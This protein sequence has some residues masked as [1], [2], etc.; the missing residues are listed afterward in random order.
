MIVTN[1]TIQDYWFGPLHLPGG[2]G[3]QL[4]V[5]DTTATSLYLTN[6]AVADAINNLYN[7]GK[8]T[9]ASAAIPFPRPTGMPSVLHGDGSPEGLVYAP[10][11]SIYL[12]RDSVALSTAIYTKTTG[13]TLNTG[14][15]AATNA[16]G[17]N[18]VGT[19]VASACPQAPSGMALCD[20]SAVSRTTYQTLFTAIC[21]GLGTFTVTIASPAVFA[22]TNHGLVAGDAV[23]FTTTGALPT[24]LSTNTVYYV[25]AAGLTS[26]NFE[27]STSRGGA[28]V[29]TSG[30]QNGVHSIVRCPWGLGDGSTTF[31]LPD[32]R[33]R[34]LVGASPGGPIEVAAL[35]TTDAVTQAQR[36]VSHHHTNA[37]TGG[38]PSSGGGQ[39]TAAPTTNTSGDANNTDAPAHAAINYF[40]QM[41]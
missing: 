19:I 3:Q 39:S 36:N 8:I 24:G 5:D 32:G 33:G 35:G 37:A 29:N 15:L 31:N 18:P 27:V 30:S 25:I 1:T 4:T 11:G 26:G 22:L 16:P 10:Q 38:S 14:W 28:A 12:R 20:G 7:S 21:P 41:S 6:D 34:V 17:T 2:I 23:Y 40:I 13:L 9:V